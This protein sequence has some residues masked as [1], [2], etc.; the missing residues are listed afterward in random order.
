MSAPHWTFQTTSRGAVPKLVVPVQ[1][2]ADEAFASVVAR[3]TRANVLG[4]TQ[5]I[6][7]EVGLELAHPG[8]AGQEIGG[9][10]HHLAQILGCSEVELQAIVHPYI[11]AEKRIV[12][13][14]PG[15]MR[16][17]DLLL[18]RR[19][20]AP[21][22][23][24]AAPY[25]RADWLCRYLPY[26]PTTGEEL[27]DTC[28]SCNNVLRWS[29]AWGIGSCE[30][31]REDI[32]N[33]VQPKLPANLLEPYR[34]FAGLLSIVPEIRESARETLDQALSE[35]PQPILV[36]LILSL[37]I[38]LGAEP[39]PIGRAR[40]RQLGNAEMA[41][42]AAAGM[43]LIEDWPNRA[44]RRTRTLIE[45]RGEEGDRKDVIRAIRSLGSERAFH[46]QQVELF[47]EVLPEIFADTRRA[48]GL[49]DGPVFLQWDICRQAGISSQ[50]VRSLAE[51]GVLPVRVVSGDKRC[52]IQFSADEAEEFCQRRRASIPIETVASRLGLPIYAIEQLIDAELLEQ[53]LHPAVL[54]IDQQPRVTHAS[55]ELLRQ[56]LANRFLPS[57][58]RTGLITLQ[59]L[60]RRFG[61]GLKAWDQVLGAIVS[62]EVTIYRAADR[63]GRSL[64]DQ[65]MCA[66]ES[67]VV[68]L[69]SWS[70]N[71]RN[72]QPR[73]AQMSQRDASE[74]LNLNAIQI[75]PTIDSGCI[76]FERC[77]FRLVC[78]VADVLTYAR[79][80]VPPSEL[81]DYFETR[82]DAVHAIVRRMFPAVE[83]LPG[84]WNREQ[85]AKALTPYGLLR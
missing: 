46:R 14:G 3:A 85:M 67:F 33:V 84:G 21:E 60:S 54:L 29:R 51:A 80:M 64:I 7:R 32:S 40:L 65:V 47:R 63:T 56:R 12:K 39:K 26:D 20:I 50:E 59:R 77:G 45:G 24:R 31:C 55:F 17:S 4:S 71:L 38:A 2:Y 53:E 72:G 11:D 43:E 73:Q 23:V 13:W 15:T 41:A 6:L 78:S 18:D 76:R 83:K 34:R 74:V 79:K 37:G 81:A 30:N 58:D 28:P 52:N 70:S 5:I 36:D 57:D 9:R 48:V 44:Q 82:P 66:P 69:S 61:G 42:A 16:R 75:K 1:P 8:T 19:R 68:G 35:I 27:L 49:L 62:G 25:V 10:T 22:A